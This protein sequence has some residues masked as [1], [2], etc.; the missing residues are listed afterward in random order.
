MEKIYIMENEMMELYLTKEELSALPVERYTKI[1]EVV[2]SRET[3]EEAIKYLSRFKMIGF[4]TETRPS[5]KKGVLHQVS[6]IQLATEEKTFLFIL[7]LD[8]KTPKCLLV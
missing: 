5:F 4:D 1:T 8:V 7:N 3:A 6:L 2:D